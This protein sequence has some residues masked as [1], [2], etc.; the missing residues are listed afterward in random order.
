MILISAIALLALSLG[1]VLWP[2]CAQQPD[3]LDGDEALEDLRE[4]RLGLYR[5][6]KELDFDHAVGKVASDQYLAQRSELQH[7]ALLL[8]R[9]AEELEAGA[10]GLDAAVEAL[11]QRRQSMAEGHMAGAHAEAAQGHA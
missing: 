7:G 1:W 6:I 3:G 2:L 5:Q 8:V 11:V 10:D 4:Q 9:R